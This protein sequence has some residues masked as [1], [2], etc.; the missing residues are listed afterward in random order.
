MT[1]V[2]YIYLWKARPDPIAGTKDFK[3]MIEIGKAEAEAK[4]SGSKA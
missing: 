4:I 1:V 3:V 2:M